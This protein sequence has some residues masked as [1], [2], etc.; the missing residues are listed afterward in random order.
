MP[1]VPDFPEITE[2]LSVLNAL[3]IKWQLS[4]SAIPV[5]SLYPVLSLQM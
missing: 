5:V 1:H 4:P 2:Y 3:N